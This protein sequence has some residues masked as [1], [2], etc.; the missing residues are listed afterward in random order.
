M[1]TRNLG[2]RGN[3]RSWKKL[4]SRK[5]K[6]QL[7]IPFSLA[8]EE[9][10]ADRQDARPEAAAERRLH[11][12]VTR[13]ITIGHNVNRSPRQPTDIPRYSS[14]ATLLDPLTD[15]ECRPRGNGVFLGLA[16]PIFLAAQ[17]LFPP[18]SPPLLI[19]R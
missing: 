2:Y 6:R 11:R 10:G 15:A 18:P 5:E 3:I 13:S 4:H 14:A 12:V 9:H 16:S 19:R 8:H 1:E 7:I 17:S